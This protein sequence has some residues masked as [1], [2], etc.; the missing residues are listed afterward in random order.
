MNINQDNLNLLMSAA[1][2]QAD[3][4]FQ[5]GEVP[6]GAVVAD[7][8]SGNCT[9]ISATHNLVEQNK[10]CSAHAEILALRQASAKLNNWRLD[11]CVL[12]VTLEPCTMC[13][14]AIMLARIPLVVFGAHDPRMGAFGSIYD[15]STTPTVT[16]AP[17]II[18]GVMKEECE[19]L[20][21]KFFQ[22]R[23]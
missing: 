9:I 1:L 23:R 11:N 5:S 16:T 14:G 10:D 15:L 8:T 7:M 19:T 13:A 2:K 6:V 18:S 3:L 12:C 21:K 17:R 4:A 22:L 20:L